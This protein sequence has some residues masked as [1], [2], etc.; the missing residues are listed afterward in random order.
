MVHLFR[1]KRHT[2]RQSNQNQVQLDLINKLIDLI[3]RLNNLLGLLLIYQ[4]RNPEMTAFSLF[5]LIS[6][7]PIGAAFA[8]KVLVLELC[9]ILPG[10]LVLELLRDPTNVMFRDCAI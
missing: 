2:R 4:I 10:L 7:S 3:Q 9:A 1:S 8:G 5:C 6:K